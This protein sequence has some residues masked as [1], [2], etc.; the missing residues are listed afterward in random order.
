MADAAI[1]SFAAVELMILI[2]AEE[3]TA[4]SV[5]V[6]LCVFLFAELSVLAERKKRWLS[7]LFLAVSFAVT[8]SAILAAGLRGIGLV[9]FASVLYSTAFLILLSRKVSALQDRLHQTCDDG[10]ELERLLR[11][12]N[13][14]LIHEQDAQVRLATMSERNR[15]AREIHDKV[16]HLLSRA[17][18]YLGAVRTVNKDEMMDRQL[19]IL[20]DT[21]DEAMQKMRQSVHDLHDESIDLSGNLEHILSELKNFSVERDLDLDRD[22]PRECKLAILGITE[23][24]VTNI[25]RHSN[26]TRVQVILHENRDFCTLSI[27]DNGSVSEE[28]RQRVRSGLTDGIGLSNIRERARSCGG[29]A[30]FYTDDGFT[31]YARLPVREETNAANTEAE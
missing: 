26:G 21:L 30:Y 8:V 24:A 11:A 14:Y 18:L 25:I 9:L 28:I 1:R 15:I 4:R 5:A 22:I 23:E 12:Q 31:V 19:S 17:I 29:D 3:I 16:G 10:K 20:S 6:S 27:S 13:R 7:D 2:N